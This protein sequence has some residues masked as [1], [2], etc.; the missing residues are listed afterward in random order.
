[1]LRPVRRAARRDDGSAVVENLLVTVLLTALALAVVQFALALHVR[2]TVTDA[3]SEGARF[4]ALAGNGTT[5][6]IDRTRDLI[7]TAVGEGYVNAVSASRARDGGQESLVVTVTG[8]LP[9]IGLLGV[10]EGLHAVGRA[11][12]ET[13]DE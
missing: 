13:V 2:T 12:V 11:A 6:A 4:G 5:E 8:T 1:M 9:V 7:G 3:A 10:G